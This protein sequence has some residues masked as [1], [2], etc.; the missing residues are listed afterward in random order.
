MIEL[1]DKYFKIAVIN[2][3]KDLKEN[4][5]SKRREVETVKKN[6]MKTLELRNIIPQSKNS[7]MGADWED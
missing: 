7:L 6:Q 2:I 1:A 5:N 3:V 4:K